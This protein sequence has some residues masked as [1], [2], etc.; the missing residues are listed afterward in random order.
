M[1]TY[2][3]VPAHSVY[4]M[5][6]K[7]SYLNVNLGLSHLGLWSVNFFLIATLPDHCLLVPCISEKPM[8]RDAVKL[9]L[10]FQIFIC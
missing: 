8:R 4:D 3:E 9:R 1:A 2:W 5:F 6:S 7:Y 10:L